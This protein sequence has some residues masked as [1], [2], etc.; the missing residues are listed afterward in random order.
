MPREPIICSKITQKPEKIKASPQYIDE[1]VPSYIYPSAMPVVPDPVLSVD[2]PP[3][4]STG[5][6]FFVDGY[7]K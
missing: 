1:I 5:F 7:Q 2:D 3:L 6:Q 4:W